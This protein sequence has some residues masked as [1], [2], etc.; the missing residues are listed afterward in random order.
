MKLVAYLAA[1]V[2][3]AA[4]PVLAAE[5]LDRVIARATEL[6]G[7]SFQSCGTISV[8][9]P[10]GE[11]CFLAAYEQKLPA[12]GTFSVHG[13]TIDVA[14]AQVLTKDGTF[15]TVF[16]SSDKPGI[17]E[18]RCAEPFVALEFTRKRVR[19]R[20]KYVAPL[21]A[22]LLNEPPVWLTSKE[23]QPKLL[24]SSEIP[25]SACPPDFEGKI[26]V[27]LLVDS[28]G[29][30]PEVQILRLPDGCSAS[31]ISKTFKTWRFSPPKRNGESI[32][33]VKV[34]TVSF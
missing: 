26:P 1:I 8:T 18:H 15:V 19:C 2:V 17:S 29:R 16:A 21:G 33:T 27:Q 31:E 34:F 3:G 12:I 10:E 32:N 25:K 11:D 13:G 23:E 5:P 7:G 6:T 22:S 9:S 4:G 24:E 20:E 14:E 30:V 28:S